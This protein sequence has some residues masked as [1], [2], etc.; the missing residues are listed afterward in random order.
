VKTL[1]QALV[2]AVRRFSAWA[3]RDEIRRLEWALDDANRH[4]KSMQVFMREYTAEP[5]ALQAE[6]DRLRRLLWETRKT[7]RRLKGR[8]GGVDLNWPHPPNAS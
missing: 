7:F 8:P 2:R 4:V 1:R 3:W 5:D 6:I